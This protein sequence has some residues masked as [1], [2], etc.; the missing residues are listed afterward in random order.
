VSSIV[1][2]KFLNRLLELSNQRVLLPG[3][4]SSKS[5]VFRFAWSFWLVGFWKLFCD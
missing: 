3:L 2:Q 1:L 4:S 5:K